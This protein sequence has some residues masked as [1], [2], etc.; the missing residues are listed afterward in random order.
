MSACPSPEEKPASAGDALNEI[1][2]LQEQSRVARENY[3]AIAERIKKLEQYLA[4]TAGKL[5]PPP[6]GKKKE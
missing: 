4:E 6:E 1:Q 2:R 3:A 5:Q